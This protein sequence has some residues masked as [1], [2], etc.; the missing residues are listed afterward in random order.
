MV[1]FYLS[2]LLPLRGKLSGDY[3]AVGI[4]FNRCLIFTEVPLSAKL[5]PALVARNQ[6]PQLETG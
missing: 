1:F 4:G 6:V 3:L 2:G 5:T